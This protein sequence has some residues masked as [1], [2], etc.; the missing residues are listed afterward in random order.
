[1]FG[2]SGT[3]VGFKI[4]GTDFSLTLVQIIAVAPFMITYLVAYACTLTAHQARLEQ[5]CWVIDAELQRWG[6]PTSY[7]L[8]R[9][10]RMYC[11]DEA[12]NESGDRKTR[13][14]SGHFHGIF[15]AHDALMGFGVL[16]AYVLAAERAF[17]L[18]G[19]EAG[20]SPEKASVLT[21][22]LLA[23][24]GLGGY[25]VFASAKS[26]KLRGVV[27][28]EFRSNDEDRKARAAE[29][30]RAEVTSLLRTTPDEREPH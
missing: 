14:F 1:L 16:G 17:T 13:E 10:L 6:C 23:A 7:S 12:Q 29:G 19:S 11:K 25:A 9:P 27:F 22:Y 30:P 21:M 15:Y 4:F 28:E 20:S 26:R 18:Y 3:T 8:V 2:A 24:T 5:E